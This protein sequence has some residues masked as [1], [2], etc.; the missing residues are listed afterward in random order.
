MKQ[1]KLL[2]ILITLFTAALIFSGDWSSGVMAKEKEKLTT[3]TGT[4]R[5][6]GNVP[7][8][9][10]V[11]TS[12]EGK[13]YSVIGETK[14]VLAKLQ[15]K[16]IKI[17]GYLKEHNGRYTKKTIKLVELTVIYTEQ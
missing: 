14:D 6:V 4:F 12:D 17:K 8:A 10:V 15:A 3:L 5:M 9:E 13:S 1:R 7:F 11:F 2:W 16:K